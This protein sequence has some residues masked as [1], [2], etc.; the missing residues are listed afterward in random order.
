MKGDI[1]MDKIKD[2]LVSIWDMIMALV[3]KIFDKETEG[4]EN[5]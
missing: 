3:L 1:T 2:L 4:K 5:E